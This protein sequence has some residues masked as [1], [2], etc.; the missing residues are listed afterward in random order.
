MAKDAGGGPPDDG[1]IVTETR[2]HVFLVGIDRPK[3][4]NGITP[5]MI[6]DLAAAYTAYEADDDLRC[7]VLHGVG[8]NFTAGIQLDLF[9]LNTELAPAGSVD[10]LALHAPVAS[11]PVLTAVQGICFTIGIELMLAG[12]IT[13]AAEN[14][15]FAMLE[16]KRG[17][18]PVGGATMRMVERA[19][20]GNA[21]R[22]LL[23][24]DEWNAAEALR[25]GFVQEVVA[26]GKQ[27]ERAVEIA[28]TIA[29]QAPLAVREVKASSRLSVEEGPAAAVA[30]FHSQLE[31]LTASEDFAEGVQ[32]FIER[33][34]GR[35]RGK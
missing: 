16:V 19:G 13:V 28:E 17:V 31:K 11:K 4:L 10:P 21:M 2:G 5:Q 26:T 18:L 33:R 1:R 14:T 22:Y 3:K 30:A 35:F 7:L 27:L 6:G 29:R 8:D 12:D 24:G 23:T 9:D 34:E 15:R 25:L 20:W 32:S